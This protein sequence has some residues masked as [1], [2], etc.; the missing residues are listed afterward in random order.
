MTTTPTTTR[1]A[2]SAAWVV[3]PVIEC[4]DYTKQAIQDL[5]AQQ[6]PDAVTRI[7]LVDNGSSHDTRRALELLQ[8]EVPDHRLLCWW[9]DFP[10][11]GPPFG[12]LDATWN[13]ALEFC[14]AAGAKEALVVN[15]D[16][17]LHPNTYACLR[18]AMQ[19]VDAL[20]V[21]AV[22]VTEE[23]FALACQEGSEPGGAYDPTSWRNALAVG[24]GG[25]D[26]SCF[27][28]SKECHARFQ[29]DPQFSYH[30]DNDY[31]WRLR[32][33]GEDFRIF[34][35]NVP[36][37]HYGS[38]T[39]NRSPEVAEA[40]KAIFE[41]HQKCYVEKWGGLPGEEKYQIPYAPSELVKAL[42]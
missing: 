3:L 15:N 4:L 26:F 17:R 28:I 41:A 10:L 34:S 32:I 25:P 13:R 16:V 6:L 14:W 31:H 8:L 22:G 18:T 1:T 42:S 23:Q 9:H 38:K 33:A 24:G 29:F 21:S 30:G 35:I 27:L 37:L 36:Y 2:A 40:Y 12:T 11:G 19:K 7:L 5:L 20:F 39:I